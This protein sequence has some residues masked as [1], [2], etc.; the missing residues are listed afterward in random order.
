MT[1]TENI[2]YCV[3]VADA[4]VGPE[5]LRM[6]VSRAGNLVDA[7]GHSR[8]PA[9]AHS[10]GCD[11]RAWPTLHATAEEA[12]AEL[13]ALANSCRHEWRYTDDEAICSRCGHV[14]AQYVPPA[15]SDRPGSGVRRGM[16]RFA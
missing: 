6:R 15:D 14:E 13:S 10:L 4:T 2:Y 5:V 8:W 16:G 3:T 1:T 11:R 9:G 12:E 7:G